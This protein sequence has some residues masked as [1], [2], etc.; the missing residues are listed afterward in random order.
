M[1]G[2]ARSSPDPGQQCTSPLDSRILFVVV[3]L[4]LVGVIA[5][6]ATT[7][8]RGA[9]Y[10]WLHA[11]RVL[12][13]GVT[14]T[15]AALLNH[16]LVWRRLRWALL[17][18]TAVLLVL[19]RL[20]GLACGVAKRDLPL[21]F[22]SLQPAELAKYALILWLAGYFA[23]LAE[24]RK[25]PNF[26]NTVVKPGLVVMV[27]ALLTLAQPSVGTST[28]MV[29]SCL[30]LFFLAGVKVRYL[31]PVAV[32][33]TVLVAGVIRFQPYANRRWRDFVN[34]NRYHQ[35][36]SLIAIGSGQLLGTGLGEGRQKLQFLPKM[37][38]DFIF[39]SVG[40]E[41]GFVGSMVIFLLYGV[42]F[43]R[44]MRVSREA[45]GTFSQ[46]LAA[47]VAVM[48]FMYALVH[49]AVTLGLVPTTGQPL[50]FVSYGG[51]ALVTNMTAAGVLLNI[52]R[53]RRSRALVPEPAFGWLAASRIG[54]AR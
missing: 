45:S 24:D 7:L 32:A 44:G 33:G 30:V 31:L 1:F 20:I 27:I 11:V 41:S 46:L 14:M 54:G 38:N 28:I 2:V 48:L 52:S 21:W 53:Y 34:G 12:V 9:S 36:Q 15:V 3:M 23:D 4:V 10:L 37:H 25:E 19:T 39:A 43:L 40:E 35:Q 13:G 8:P 16:A 42:L 29:G 18:S 47:G 6:Y 50:P 49:V 22:V 5:V 17:S 51:S 26:R